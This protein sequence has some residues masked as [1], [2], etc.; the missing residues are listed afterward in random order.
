MAASQ[1]LHRLLDIRQAEE[2]RS[3][4]EMEIA[5]AE[6]RRI[7]AAQAATHE[8][9]ERARALVTSSAQTGELTDRIAG[10]QEMR[11]TERLQRMLVGMVDAARIGAQE[12]RHEF[13]SSCIARRQVETLANAK[14]AEAIAEAS[15]KTQSALDDW[16]RS[17]QMAEM[18]KTR[19]MCFKSDI[20]L[21]K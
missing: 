20:P 9:G 2:E 12:K 15:R 4:S 8:R 10:L 1:R 6:L 19:A 17:Q 13:L 16:H 7:E 14:S 3:Q 5:F 11:T 21:T 18:R